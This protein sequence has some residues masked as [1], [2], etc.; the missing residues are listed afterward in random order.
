VA[1]G[2]NQRRRE[3]GIR[4]AL[5]ATHADVVGLAVKDGMTLVG[6]GLA[7]G[8]LAAA[9]AA[10]FLRGL[11]YGLEPL[12]P[13]A[14]LAAPLLFGLVALGASWFPARRAA[15]VDPMVAMRAE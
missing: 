10:R 13:Q 12:D 8:L 5:G 7:I 4:I 3:I 9:A 15:R 14:F 11:L 6:V 1:F 2:V